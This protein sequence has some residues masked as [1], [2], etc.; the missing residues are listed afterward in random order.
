MSFKRQ[1]IQTA[2]SYLQCFYHYPE[3]KVERR[4]KKK[5]WCGNCPMHVTSLLEDEK[6]LSGLK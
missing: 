5:V 4:I 2:N 6:H 1:S 3:Q